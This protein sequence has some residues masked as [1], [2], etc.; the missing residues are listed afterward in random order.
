MALPRP[1]I[2]TLYKDDPVDRPYA[3]N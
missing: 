1:L 3:C 2:Y